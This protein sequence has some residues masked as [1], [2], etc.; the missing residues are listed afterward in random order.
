MLKFNGLLEWLQ[1][2]LPGSA[3]PKKAARSE[4][5]SKSDKANARK[6]ENALKGEKARDATGTKGAAPAEPEPVA[7]EAIMKDMPNGA[8]ADP[9]PEKEVGGDAGDAGIP[10]TMSHEEL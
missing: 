1:A 4:S 5:D 3:K 10:K 9:H 6:A 7:E 8:P 2:Y